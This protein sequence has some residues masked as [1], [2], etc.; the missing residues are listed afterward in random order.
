MG[1]LW[2]VILVSLLLCSPLI[3]TKAQNSATLQLG[4]SVERAL[5]LKQVHEFSVD[6]AKNSYV[7]VVVEQHGIDVVVKVI[8]PAGTTVN[9]YDTPNGADGPENV[10]FTAATAGTY[11]ITV[12]PLA[13]ESPASGRYQIKLVEL[14]EATDREINASKNT[15]EARAKGLALLLEV[16]GAISQIKSPRTRIQAQLRAAELLRESD[17]KRASKYLSDAIAGVKEV[18]SSVDAGSEEYLQEYALISQLRSEVILALAAHDTDAALS[19]LRATTPSA[20]PIADSDQLKMHESALEV[21]IANLIAADKPNL[22][23]QIARQNLKKGYPTG[24]MGIVS[25]LTQQKPELAAE[26]VHEIA[27]KLVAE[28][29]LMNNAE[30]ATM[31]VSLAQNYVLPSRGIKTPNAAA[32]P[33]NNVVSEEEYSQLIQ[34][35]VGEVLSTQRP[36]AMYGQGRGS[37][38]NMVVGLRSLG[39]EIDK[40][41][42][43][44]SAALQ[45]K[46]EEIMGA[47]ES[48]LYPMQEYHNKIANGS[49]EAALEVIEGAPSEIQEQLYMQLAGREAISGNV[50]QARQIANQ[51]VTTP[52]QRKQALAN[53]EQ[54]EI[55]QAIS[56]GKYDEALRKIGNLRTASERAA[57]LITLANQLGP[58]Q[59]PATALSILEQARSLLAPSPQAQDQEQMMALFEI[60][61]AFSQYDSKRPF[62]IVDPLIDQFNELCAAART[63]DGFGSE[64]FEHDELDLDSGG[65]VSEIA[66]QLST[67]LGTLALANFDRAKAA[68]DKLRL[69]EVRLRAY[70]QIAQQTIEGEPE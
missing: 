30:A 44:A 40:V 70:L 63:L 60:A 26:L 38:W 55:S 2:T 59:K 24:V 58:E 51:H 54:Q 65:G 49:M 53:I 67:T 31:A 10:S 8:S 4:V 18:L 57:Q 21:S 19:V 6:A 17:A 12:E 14:R 36:V 48:L 52:Y 23:V 32:S 66:E 20:S 46:Q 5:A 61:R 28:E 34:K 22:A 41:V 33:F 3:N 50:S 7:Q 11:R 35:M 68:S 37:F 42:N 62:E 15:E 45:K 47:S 1:R 29:K 25:Q 16:D 43:G 39:P 9:E 64:E 69:P 56:K 13:S 27:G